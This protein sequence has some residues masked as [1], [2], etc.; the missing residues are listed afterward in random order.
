MFT[1]I[2]GYTALMGKDEQKAFELL[3]QNRQIQKP[4]IEQYNGKWI[5]E[6]G[7]GIMA[8]FSTVLDAV[9]AAIKIQEACNAA[10]N[11]K[12]RIGIHL[13]EVI[14]ENDDVFGDGVNI[15]SRIQAI[16]NPGSVYISQSVYNN[17]ANKKGIATHFVKTE[18]LKNV[19]EPVRIYEVRIKQTVDTATI[20][21]PRTPP[22]SNQK[23]KKSILFVA[24]AI[25]ILL[26]GGYFVYN[27]S[28]MTASHEKSKSKIKSIVVLYFNNMTGDPTQEYFSDGITEE[29]TSRLAK[30][31]GLYVPGRTSAFFY[32]GKAVSAIQIAQE[33]KVDALVEGSLRKSG[34]LVKI[35]AQF[36][37]GKTG[38]HL[39][40]MD[41]AKQFK[42]IFEAQDDIA[43]AVAKKVEA[44]ISPETIAKI[45]ERGTDNVEA[46]DNFLRGSF[47]HYTKYFNTRLYEDFERSKKY[48][49]AAIKLD[50]GYA[51]AYAGLSDLY[52]SYSTEKDATDKFP[53]IFQLREQLARKALALNSNS[54]TANRAMA[55]AMLKQQKGRADSS[56]FFARKAY[57]LAPSDPV[58]CHTLSFILSAYGLN[59]LALPIGQEAVRT[60]PFE[61]VQYAL[62]GNQYAMLGK[63]AEAKQALHKSFDLTNDKFDNDWMALFWLTYFGDFRTV[64]ERL[65]T[66]PEP[67]YD[68]WKSFLH[69]SKGEFSKIDASSRRDTTLMLYVD[70]LTDRSKV[71]KDILNHLEEG[72]DKGTPDRIFKYDFL[73]TAYYFDAYRN[74][75]DFEK[76]LAKAKKVKDANLMKYENFDVSN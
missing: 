59:S 16:A 64:E 69:A 50:P 63:Y 26:V 60:D 22:G 46:Y 37:D 51:D 40:S 67:K 3:N 11:F 58:S 68:R 17:I 74:N 42:D 54:T 43:L 31:K 41:T 48:F 55:W 1:D 8:S 14:F 21:S 47:F 27:S 24:G 30:I 7:D 23:L 10:K 76:I 5:K 61:P 32:K 2:V 15:A 71:S 13:G 72:I 62:L 12:L 57:Y 52:D 49:E 53:D 45:N 18:H 70:L 39:W 4:I 33:L 35:S 38:Y 29:I 6:L 25:I 36:I 20:A 28:L 75:A 65:E 73:K 44:D 56:L 9:T 34:D 19:K 66:R